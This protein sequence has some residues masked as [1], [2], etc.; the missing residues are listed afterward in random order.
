MIEW[1][2]SLNSMQQYLF[3]GGLALLAMV[4]LAI[5]HTWQAVNDD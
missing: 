1:F 2:F 5:R 4:V 3:L